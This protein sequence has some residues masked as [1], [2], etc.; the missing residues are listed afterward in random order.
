MASIDQAQWSPLTATSLVPVSA[1]NL[2]NGEV[3]LWAADD[4]FNYGTVGQAYSTTFDPVSGKFTDRLVNNTGHNLFCPGTTNLADGRL[5]VN[6]GSQA[7]ATSLYDPSTNTWTAGGKMQITRGYNANTLLQDGSVFTLGGSFS[8][9]QGNKHGEVWTASAGWKRLTGVPVDNMVGPDSAGVYRGDNHMWLLPTGNGMVLH[10]GPSANMNWID[11][12]GNGSV[13]PAGRR[14]DDAYSM[15]GTAVMYDVGKIL[16]A[17]GSPSYQNVNATAGSYIIDVNDGLQVRKIAPMAYARAYHNSVVL[18]NGQVIV[19]GGQSRPVMFTDGNAVLVPELF[20]PATEKFTALPPIAVPRNYHSVALL[21]PDAR[22]LSAGGG[23]CGEGCAA[24]HANLQIL[25]PHYL[26]KSDGTPATRPVITNAPARTGYGQTMQVTTDSP[27]TA[28]ALVR[29][30]STTHTVN[31]DQRRIPLTFIGTGV[32]SYTVNVPTNPGWALPGYYMLFALNADGVPAVARTVL[33]SNSNTPVIATVGDQS[34]AVGATVNLAVAATSPTGAALT[35]AATGLP[36]GLALNPATGTI[37]GTPTMPGR[38]AVNLTVGD[39]VQKVSHEFVWTVADASRP[40][41]VKFE[42]LSAINGQALASMAEFN[43]LDTKGAVLPRTGWKVS[44]DSAETAA[45]SGIDGNA[46]DGN[47]AT[48]WLTAATPTPAPMPHWLV[49][50]MGLAQKISA[51]RYLPRAGGGEGTVAEFRVYVSADGVN[52]NAPVAAGNLADLGAATAEK[53]IPVALVGGINQA[54]MIATPAPPSVTQGQSVSLK[55]SATDPDGDVLTYSASG[56][57]SGLT[58]HASTGVIDGAPDVGGNYA[59]TV[60]A[61]DPGGMSASASFSW[62]V[63][64]LPPVIAP[65]ATAPAVSHGAV[66]YTASA[67]GAGPFLYQ[68][69]F[70]DGSPATGFNSSAG[71]SHVYTTPGIYTVTLTVRNGA[72]S[73][74]RTFLQAVGAQA[75]AGA[76]AASSGLALERGVGN[77]RLWAVNP[78]NDTVSVFDTATSRKLADIAVGAQPQTVAQAPD[79][80]LWV[81][82]KDSATVSIISP[83]SLSVVQTISLARGSQPHGLVFAKDG[84]ALV[85][86][87]ALGQLVKLSS[88][89]ARLAS[90]DVGPN[91]RHISRTPDGSRLLVSRFITRPQPGEGTAAVQ[92]TVNGVKQGGEVL[93]VDASDLRLRRT[94]VLQHSDKADSTTQGR[95]VPNYLGAAAVSPDGASAWVPS[96]QDNIQRGALRDRLDLDFQN[97]VR[98]VSSRI[99]LGS[100]SE[101]Y[102]A[103]VDHDNAGV[104]SAAVYHPSGAYLFVTLESSRQLAVLDAAAGRE[105]LRVDTGRAPQS[106]VVSDDGR[107]LFVSNFMDRTVGVY[108]LTRL[109]NFGEADVPLQAVLDSGG[110]E[111][112]APE[113]LKGKQFFY[114]ARDPRLARDGY[115][116]CAS[117][118][119]DAGHDGR[120]WDFTSL[121]EGLRRTIALKGRAGMGNGFLHWSAN[122][123][124]VQDFEGQIRK[125]A[126]GTGLMSDDKFNAG[127]RAQPLG[128]PKAGQSADLDALAAYLRSLAKFA[129][130]PYRDAGGAL[131]E[132]AQAGSAIFAD[133]NC[134]ACHGGSAFTASSDGSGL[135]NIGTLKA[136]SGKR[137]GAVLTGIDIPTLRDVWN[138]SSYLHDGS[139]LTLGDA[140][141]AHGTAIPGALLTATELTRLSDYLR[142]IGSDETTAP[143]I[144]PVV[145]GPGTVSMAVGSGLSLP[146]KASTS[147]GVLS[148]SATGLPAGMRIDPVS[149]EISGTA[150]TPGRYVVTVLVGNG[151]Q[152]VNVAFLIDISPELA[153]TGLLAQYFDN[154]NL[155][156]TPVMQSVNV[157]FVSW[158]AAAPVLGVPADNF[159]IRWSGMVEAPV[160]GNVQFRAYADDGM[161]LWIDNK[162]LVDAWNTPNSDSATI[163]VP[164]VAGRRYAVTL[165]YNERRGNAAMRLEWKPPGSSLWTAVPAARLYATADMGTGLSA[166]YFGNASLSG[167]PVMQRVEAPSFDW[168]GAAPAKGLPADGFSVRWTGTMEASATGPMQLRTFSDDGVRVWIDGQMIIDDWMP[169]GGKYD[170][171]SIAMVAGQRHAV[172]IE[173]FER[174]GSAAMRFEWKPPGVSEWRSVPAAFLYPAGASERSPI[175][176]YLQGGTEF[177][178]GPVSGQT[179]VGIE[180]RAGPGVNAVQ[181]FGAPVYWPL[182]GVASGVANRFALFNGE[183]LVRLY[184]QIGQS[185]GSIAQL[186]FVTNTGRV[187]GP[188]GLPDGQE[189]VSGFDYTV[190]AGQRVVGLAG[191]SSSSVNAIGVVLGPR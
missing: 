4:P 162:L 133:R 48:Y 131:T 153:G 152:S 34:T 178:D 141:Q 11:T 122:F 98:A 25:S 95:G 26:F 72:A 100:L 89:G 126:G 150:T 169:H 55:L 123:D 164:M 114:D 69:D 40:R 181:G 120:T 154:P 168:G 18:P 124:E 187:L 62:S 129:P 116:S 158:G 21:L 30:S 38:Y 53:T 8:G 106:V 90:L 52:W 110:P 142:Q 5:L 79:G 173:Y 135:R 49:V 147:A 186:S 134:A 105:V 156:G 66:Q 42:A 151:S 148:Y 75:V 33:L 188:V 43:I 144:Y 132:S 44:V 35:H 56:L 41:Y 176:G 177:S 47:A 83:G 31:N 140:V 2:P 138:D 93:V 82:N 36:P 60:T 130:S 10:A 28:F 171:A 57:P 160:T 61:T 81:V 125:L 9:G 149:G 91:P 29:A 67:N 180:L 46:I 14:G 64:S 115:L 185:S 39:G 139:A 45:E 189:A 68:W 13:T 165:E 50:D 127:T 63:S 7:G 97:T 119:N 128:D 59:V 163:S 24:N 117:C 58:L 6:G 20:D 184:G 146:I 17:G 99:A 109:I 121:G 113:V 77:T 86:L 16:K 73:S 15:S 137:L 118:H 179:L 101:D 108:D 94:V 78:D 182:H 71:V 92:T 88:G 65:V 191:R 3:L 23:L 111:K 96:K 102:A 112:L 159:S 54:P 170:T 190:P 87:E 32:N 157:P 103:R 172:T 183:Y 80:R 167:A 1:A 143:A 27:V 104:A 174:S 145:Q 51:V 161:R 19:I 166:Q 107:K 70:G 37:T 76:A 22:V 84:N 85:T 136:S 12:R 175:F 74:S 155:L